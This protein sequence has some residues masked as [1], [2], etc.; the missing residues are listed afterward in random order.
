[1]HIGS[2]QRNSL[3]RWSGLN[4]VSF[5]CAMLVDAAGRAAAKDTIR[6][7][8]KNSVSCISGAI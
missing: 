2:S 8:I 1:M 3:C 7:R 6:A 4:P 5:G